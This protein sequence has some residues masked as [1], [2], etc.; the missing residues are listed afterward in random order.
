MVTSQNF[1]LEENP[2]RVYNKFLID[3]TNNLAKIIYFGIYID[4]L[5]RAES[6]SVA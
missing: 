1:I 6:F 2:S 5:V 3:S 4:V